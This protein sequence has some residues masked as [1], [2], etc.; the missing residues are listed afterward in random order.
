VDE[1]IKRAFEIAEFASTFSAQKQILK[2]EYIQNLNY[3]YN[4]G[5]FFITKELITFVKTLKDISTEKSTVLVDQNHTPIEILDIN[6][7]LENLLS[8]YYFATNEY[9]TRFQN[10]KT[11]RTIESVLEK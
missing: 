10:L 5:I 2:E 11:S 4:G 3:Y 8:K 9:F 6:E 1:K 7:F